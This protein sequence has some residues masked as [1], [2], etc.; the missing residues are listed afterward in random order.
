MRDLVLDTNVALDLL[1]FGDPAVAPVRDGLARGRLR[2]LATAAMRE[3]LERVLGYPALARRLQASGLTPQQVLDEFDACSHRV[4]AAAVAAVACRDPDD[5]CFIDLAVHHG[6]TLLSKD[7]A[8]LALAR[9]LSAL[10]VHAA[11]ALPDSSG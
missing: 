10:G 5:Q 4:D 6:C 9:R 3:E 8:V 2:W 7:A 1:V 11:A